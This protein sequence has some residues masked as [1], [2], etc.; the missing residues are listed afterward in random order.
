MNRIKNVEFFKGGKAIFTIH[1]NS[2]EHFTYKI[3]KAKYD[4]SGRK[5]DNG[6]Y[7]ASLMTGPDNNYSYSYMGMFNPNNYSI[8]PTRNSKVDVEAKSW[9]VLVW[10]ISMIF[11]QKEIPEGYGIKHEGKCCRCGR[12]LTTPE[13]IENGIGPECIK[14]V[15]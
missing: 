3:N 9:K 8:R 7:F 6:P 13:S 4:I 11:H 2:G 12:R 5:V 10:G 14:N 15:R 1:N